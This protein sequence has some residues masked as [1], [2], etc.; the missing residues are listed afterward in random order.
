[1]YILELSNSM[2]NNYAVH[3]LWKCLSFAIVI[4]LSEQC[5]CCPGQCELT[6]NWLLI[7]AQHLAPCSRSSLG[8]RDNSRTTL[9]SW[10]NASFYS[11]RPCCA[12]SLITDHQNTPIVILRSDLPIVKYIYRT[13]TILFVWFIYFILFILKIWNRNHDEG[14]VIQESQSRKDANKYSAVNIILERWYCEI[15]HGNC[16]AG[17]IKQEM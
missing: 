7:V 9:F 13:H 6:T 5:K 8:K 10:N 17:K 16:S 3:L 15:K 4:G 14:A 1:M 2:C 12:I 11:H